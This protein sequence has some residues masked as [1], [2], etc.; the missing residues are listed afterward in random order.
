M[1]ELE[2][3]IVSIVNE[4]DDLTD[5]MNILLPL[6]LTD[7]NSED[8]SEV[9]RSYEK[10]QELIHK[11]DETADACLAEKAAEDPYAWGQAHNANCYCA[12][13]IKQLDK[14]CE[15]KRI[16]TEEYMNIFTAINNELHSTRSFIISRTMAKVK[17]S[18]GKI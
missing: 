13:A 7:D 16:S 10:R 15:E 1:T 17:T 11:L 6:P 2:L 18:S 12:K 8:L 9:A 14:V 4:I 5:H 3:Q